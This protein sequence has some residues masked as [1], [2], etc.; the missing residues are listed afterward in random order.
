MAKA[1]MYL[2]RRTRALIAALA[3]SAV[4]TMAFFATAAAALP[5]GF[6][7]VVPQATPSPEQFQRLKQ[8][9][10]QSVRIP[11]IWGGVQ[12]NRGGALDWST[13]DGLVKNAAA[14][15]L[16]VLP[17]ISGAPTWAIPQARVVESGNV[18]RSPARL[19]VSGVA[20]SAWVNLLRGAVARYGPNGTLWAENPLIPKQP[21]R[22]WQIWN[23]PN[24]VYF[25]AKPNPAE[26]GKLVRL[27]STALKGADPGAKVILGG[28][29]ARPKNGIGGPSKAKG[30]RNYYATRFLEVMYERTP[31]IKSKFDQVGLHPYSYYFQQLPSTIEE[32]REVM[33][34]NHDAGKGLAIT[35]LGWSSEHPEQADLFKKG[36]GGQA[37]QLKGSFSLFKRMQVKWHLKS[38]YWFSV[39]D[40]PGSCNFCGGSGLFGEGFRPKKSWFEYVR[41]AGGT[42]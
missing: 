19:P 27:S 39:D 13:T 33:A 28:M 21:I 31:G 29:F 36:V 9:G 17:F 20:A 41:F 4:A 37:Q 16:R 7:G 32:L 1:M 26:Y 35:E 14:A 42:P 30:K 12:P 15:G 25:V 5:A 22:E 3:I 23:E 40:Q 24:F 11:I 38:V 2:S 8:G 18:V 10:V 6:W 34:E